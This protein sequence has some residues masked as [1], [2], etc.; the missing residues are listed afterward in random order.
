M[1]CCFQD[2]LSELQPNTAKSTTGLTEP[3]TITDTDMMGMDIDLDLYGTELDAEEEETKTE[4][5][6]LE[7]VTAF[8]SLFISLF[9]FILN[10]AHKMM[11][12]TCR[13]L[14][15]LTW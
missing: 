8:Y 7:Q 9:C 13:W 14:L 5:M 10:D 12:L 2:K 15:L 6:D 4:P 3:T 1:T 11:T